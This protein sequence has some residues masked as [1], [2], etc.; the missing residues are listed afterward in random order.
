VV[1]FPLGDARHASGFADAGGFEMLTTDE[2]LA[3]QRALLE[4][5]DGLDA[6]VIF[7]SDHASN[8]VPLKGTLPRDR[9][10]LLAQL[11]RAQSGALPL[12]PEWAR[13]L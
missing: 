12:R 7:R 10:R 2:L 3:E 9:E 4:H 6:R 11:G 8:Y 13:G 5:L 1:S